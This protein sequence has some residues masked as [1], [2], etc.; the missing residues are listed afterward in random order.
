MTD[1]SKKFVVNVCSLSISLI[2]YLIGLMRKQSAIVVTFWRIKE[3]IIC[4]AFFE[5]WASCPEFFHAVF[6]YLSFSYFSRKQFLYI[7][8]IWGVIIT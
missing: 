8:I 5:I 3:K 2:V 7:F 1:S 4:A 6:S